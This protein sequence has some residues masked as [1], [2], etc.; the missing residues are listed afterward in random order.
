MRYA[1]RS[2]A[3]SHL[4]LRSK[5]TWT[6]KVSNPLMYAKLAS[7][8]RTRMRVVSSVEFSTAASVT[9]PAGGIA[10]NVKS[11]PTTHQSPPRTAS[12]ETH[13]I[14]SLL[15]PTPAPPPATAHTAL[16]LLVLR[17]LATDGAFLNLLSLPPTLALNSIRLLWLPSLLTLPFT[18]FSST[19]L[20][21]SLTTSPSTAITLTRSSIGARASGGAGGASVGA[22]EPRRSHFGARKPGLK[23]LMGEGVGGREGGRRGRR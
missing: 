7:N 19:P 14:K 11:L 4:A 15:P 22:D 10:K 17:V 8:S 21:H 12:H 20:F 5:H 2:S 23:G 6:V 1:N 9:S 18:S 13:A 16:P 3:S